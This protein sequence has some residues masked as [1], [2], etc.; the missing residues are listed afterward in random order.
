[1]Q[2]RARG[3][4]TPT[5]VWDRYLYPARWPDWAPQIRR[6]ET[7]GEVLRAGLTGRVFGPLGTSVR[8]RVDGVDLQALTWVWT[9]RLGPLSG[10]L[11]HAVRA[12]PDGSET[13]LRIEGFGPLAVLYAPIAQLALVRL[14]RPD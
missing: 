5:V 13:S 1:M 3:R 6:V 10:R 12:I 7:D 8:F 9:V 11:Q 14:V 2:L 4:A